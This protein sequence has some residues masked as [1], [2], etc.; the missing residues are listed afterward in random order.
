MKVEPWDPKEHLP[1]IQAWAGFPCDPSA[2][3]PDGWVVDRVVA[4]FLYLT[5]CDTAFVDSVITNPM[6]PMLVRGKALLALLEVIRHRCVEAGVK[7]LV[8]HTDYAGVVEVARQYGF[9][10]TDGWLL[11]GRVK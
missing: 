7:Q 11:R 5:K 2:F 8:S 4:G 3:P 1:I 6:A 9:Q 10:V